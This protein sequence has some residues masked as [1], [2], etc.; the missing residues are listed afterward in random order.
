[1]LYRIVVVIMVVLVIVMGVMMLLGF[2]DILQV[3][4][5]LANHV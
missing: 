3:F 4:C 5:K 2:I 1:M